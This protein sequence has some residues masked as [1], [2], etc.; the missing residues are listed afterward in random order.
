[1][2]ASHR[3]GL[4][5]P[6]G[7]GKQWFSWIHIDDLANIFCFLLTNY[8]GKYNLKLLDMTETELQWGY[9][10]YRLSHPI[11]QTRSLFTQSNTY[12]LYCQ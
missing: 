1:M 2:Y 9:L 8:S 10:D 12:S 4:A 5:G 6:I 7:D 11:L 3:L